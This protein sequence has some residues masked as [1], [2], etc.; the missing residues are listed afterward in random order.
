MALLTAAAAGLGAA[1]AIADTLKFSSGSGLANG[2]A[3][4][5]SD[6]YN[7]S[8]VQDVDLEKN[9]D[10]D[11]TDIIKHSILAKANGPD[12]DDSNP[13]QVKD[14]PDLEPMQRGAFSSVFETEPKS[15][16]VYSSDDSPDEIPTSSSSETNN[17][18][19]PGTDTD[20]KA[21]MK[22]TGSD[23]SGSFGSGLVMGSPNSVNS[24]NSVNSPGALAIPPS[25][26]VPLEGKAIEDK[27]E[28]ENPL[29]NEAQKAYDD[30]KDIDADELDYVKDEDAAEQVED[31]VEAVDSGELDEDKA[32]EELEKAAEDGEVEKNE[33]DMNL[34]KTL[35][36]FVFPDTAEGSED[37]IHLGGKESYD[38]ADMQDVSLSN[39][40]SE[41]DSSPDGGASGG[42]SFSSSVGSVSS[43]GSPKGADFASQESS[44]KSSVGSD[45][46]LNNTPSGSSSSGSSSSGSMKATFDKI[47]AGGIDSKTSSG[48]SS[49]EDS[50][51]SGGNV[52]SV[53]VKGNDEPLKIAAQ[54]GQIPQNAVSPKANPVT[55]SIHEVVS[56]D[57][58]K[59]PEKDGI[60][61]KTKGPIGIFTKNGQ[62][63]FVKMGK[64]KIQPLEEVDSN[65]LTYVEEIL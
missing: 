55:E 48:D 12:E 63:V 64:S 3:L 24:V 39:D 14:V 31:Y 46:S 15:E 50:G 29:L 45:K 62:D 40:S 23:S 11:V 21:T 44:A 41:S 5:G 59:W 1:K 51:M 54:N 28:V 37:G 2:V 33:L 52:G 38:A 7:A 35:A 22:D 20:I 53:E 34:V 57:W 65:K 49:F 17:G 42:P 56:K 43:G 32:E 19:G 6:V 26:Q 18:D 30:D 25:T 4:A 9:K 61:Y 13:R 8:D 60:H 16:P 10:D 27:E 47:M 58:E 36:K